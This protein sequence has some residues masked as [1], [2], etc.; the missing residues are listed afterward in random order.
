MISFPG[1][2]AK[3]RLLFF[4][5]TQSR[6][7]TGLLTGNNILGRH[8]HFMG[9]RFN[10]LCRR[11]GTEEETSIHF[12]CECE[13]L[14][15]IRHAYWVPFFWTQKMLRVWDL[16]PSGTTAK[17]WGSL[18]LTCDYG[19][20][21][22]PHLKAYLHRGRKCWNPIITHTHTQTVTGLLQSKLT[23]LRTSTTNTYCV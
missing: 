2:T 12:S 16:G 22:G 10:P 23:D 6:V 7:V 11:C 14:I 8:L 20:N 5:W 4:S 15:S 3:T 19:G 18:N 21:I 9:L 1:P 13:T 17:E